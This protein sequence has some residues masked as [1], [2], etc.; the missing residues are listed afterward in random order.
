M[1]PTLIEKWSGADAGGLT[2]AGIKDETVQGSMATILENVATKDLSG[3]AGILT[4]GFEGASAG[5]NMG[6]NNM[7]YPGSENIYSNDPANVYRPIAMALLRRSFPDIFAHKC[8][9]VQPMS[10]PYGVAFAMRMVYAGTDIEAGW[11]NVPEFAHQSGTVKVLYSWDNTTT[12]GINEYNGIGANGRKDDIFDAAGRVDETKLKAAIVA[13][14]A[15]I[16]D[17]AHITDMQVSSQGAPLAHSEG[18]VIGDKRFGV[19]GN[20]R[21]TIPGG[22]TGNMTELEF[23]LAQ[24]PIRAANRKMGASYSLESAQD[25]AAMHQG[26]N[27][28]KEMLNSLNSELNGQ[29]DREIV[30]VIKWVA[31][32]TSANV[33]GAQLTDI[34]LDPSATGHAGAL[35]RWNGEI[36]MSV[37]ASI[38]AQSNVLALT[39]GRG[40]GNFVIVSPDVATVL[41]A[42]GHQFVQY[43]GGANAS[44]SV[45]YLGKLN[46]TIDVYRDRFSTESMALVGYKGSGLSEAGVIYSPYVSALTTRGQNSGDFSPRLGVMSR[47]A[48][49]HNL[50]GAGRYY[51][52][53]RFKNMDKILPNAMANVLPGTGSM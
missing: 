46:G 30:Q 8:V 12:T 11:E 20:G 16:S 1:E 5:G 40:A 9:G 18:L 39:T 28:E 48:I 14:D 44:Q 37:I 10:L 51:R 4:E 6:T 45:S 21:P 32:D 17:V 15:D 13:A 24:R 36:Y 47:Y 50:L 19:D 42:A 53:I 41:Q 22:A 34:D 49:T 2:I 31:E 43:K 26:L 23:K 38:V 27:I 35:G 25:I 7:A 33:G 3:K 52:M 29:L